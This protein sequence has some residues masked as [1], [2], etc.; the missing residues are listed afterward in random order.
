MDTTRIIHPDCAPPYGIFYYQAKVKYPV[1]S[2][3]LLAA[4]RDFM[5]SKN[6]PPQAS[7][8]VT[9][10][11]FVDCKGTM[12]RIKVMQTDEEYKP[13][14]FPR[15]Y[16]NDLHSY[17][18]TLD[19]WPQNIDIEDIKNVNYIAFITLRIRHGEILNILP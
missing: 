18:R 11:F 2:T 6:H 4:A 17:I 10:R 7:G 15:D 16:I 13:T 5:R 19:R 1:G 9:F 8:Y 12:S 14:H 3:E